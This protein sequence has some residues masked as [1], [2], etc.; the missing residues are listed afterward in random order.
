MWQQCRKQCVFACQE[1]LNA[2]DSLDADWSFGC[3]WKCCAGAARPCTAWGVY[4]RRVARVCTVLYGTWCPP[5]L[6]V[7]RCTVLAWTPWL[8]AMFGAGRL[9]F[10]AMHWQE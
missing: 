3:L 4:E 5:R 8:A 1:V 6:V 9:L 2:L 7:Y 10:V